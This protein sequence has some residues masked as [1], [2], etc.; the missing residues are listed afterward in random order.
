MAEISLNIMYLVPTPN[1]CRK[2]FNNVNEVWTNI[3]TLYFWV[4]YNIYKLVYI[5]VRAIHISQNLLQN[6]FIPWIRSKMT[7]LEF[8]FNRET[9]NLEWL[10]QE[11]D[12]MTG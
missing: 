12:N 8:L 9:T 2:K 11:N 7:E 6:R 10:E 5:K 1:K 4:N 3:Y